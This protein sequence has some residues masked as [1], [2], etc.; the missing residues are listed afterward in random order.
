[1]NE[2]CISKFLRVGGVI[3]F[4][5]IRGRKNVKP[6]LSN[7]GIRER[8]WCPRLH[9]T[10]SR[11]SFVTWWMTYTC[12]SCGREPADLT[13]KIARRG[14]K[15]RPRTAVWENKRVVRLWVADKVNQMD[16]IYIERHNWRALN[17]LF[18]NEL[19]MRDRTA[20]DGNRRRTFN[21]RPFVDLDTVYLFVPAMT[22]SPAM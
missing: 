14:N 12:G 16:I 1:M 15:P 19:L 5:A 7:N 10:R 3:I 4:Y 13:G 17:R 21:Y 20:V 8:Q 9:R 6:P 18:R 11:M 22:L 2:L